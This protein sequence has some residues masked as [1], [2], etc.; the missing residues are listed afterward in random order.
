MITADGAVKYLDERVSMN[1][2]AYASAARGAVPDN[3]TLGAADIRC[4]AVQPS[5][6]RGSRAGRTSDRSRRY[7]PARLVS[8][9]TLSELPASS[10]PAPVNL[11]AGTMPRLAWWHLYERNT[12]SP[13][14]RQVAADEW[15]SR[16]IA[17]RLRPAWRQPDWMATGRRGRSGGVGADR[18]A[19]ARRRG[20]PWHPLALH[21]TGCAES[22]IHRNVADQDGRRRVRSGPSMGPRTGAGVL[23]RTVGRQAA[24]VRLSGRVGPDP[25]LVQRRRRATSDI[26]AGRRHSA[27][28]SRRP[29]PVRRLAEGAGRGRYGTGRR[30]PAGA[31]TAP[32]PLGS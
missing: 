15:N 29:R 16:R 28:C 31:F 10:V 26:G 8:T 17:A 30:C 25:P 32:T 21:C 18:A 9:C 13:D 7:R 1:R 6:P 11:Q 3:R 14:T 4:T 23:G 2:E 24:G 20:A 22:I 19:A 27:H 12:E 5:T